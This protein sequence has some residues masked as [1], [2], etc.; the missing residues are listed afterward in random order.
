MREKV[1]EELAKLERSGVIERINASE[2]VSPIVVA[3]KKNGEIRLCVDLRK[4][5]TAIVLDSHSLPCPHKLF[6]Q[7]SGARV[8]SKLDLSSAYHQ[9]DLAEESRDLTAFVTHEGLFRFTR[10]CFGLASAAPAFQKMMDC[11]L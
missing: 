3:R 1:S 5:N 8:F 4:P 11:I 7:L 10:A 6:H 9:L 2:W